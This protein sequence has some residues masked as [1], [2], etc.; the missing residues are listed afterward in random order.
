LR[1]ASNVRTKFSAS[2]KTGII[3]ENFICHRLVAFSKVL[4]GHYCQRCPVVPN[5]HFSCSAPSPPVR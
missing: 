2:L 3:T 1:R 4:P 5:M